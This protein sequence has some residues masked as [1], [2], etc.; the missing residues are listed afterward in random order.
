MFAGISFDS[1]NIYHKTVTAK[2]ISCGKDINNGTPE[3]KAIEKSQAMT[4]LLQSHLHM[5]GT[6]STMA[7]SISR[8]KIG[9]TAFA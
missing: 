6:T 3:G 1:S 8:L 2:Y 9:L 7:T 5:S 4:R